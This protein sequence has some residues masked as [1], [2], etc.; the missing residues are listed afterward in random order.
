MVVVI[1]GLLIS[2]AFLAYSY[3]WIDEAVVL[4]LG[5][6]RG[7][8]TNLHFLN[9]LSNQNRPVMA[10]IFLGL[11]ASLFCLQLLLMSKLGSRLNLKRML[12]L[13]GV[14]TFIFSLSY[15]FLSNDLFAYL[16]YARISIIY[17]VSPYLVSAKEF[18]NVDLWVSLLHNVDSKAVYGPGHLIYS[19]ILMILAS[20]NKLLLNFLVM[21][22]MNGVLFYLAGWS[23]FRLY[24]SKQVFGLWFFNPLLIIELLINSH[25]DLL[26]V[27]LTVLAIYFWKKRDDVKAWVL[28]WLSVMMKYFS[29]LALP[30]F[31]LDEKGRSRYFKL[32]CIMI[33][34]F[35]LYKNGQVWY[36]SWVYM[37][38]PFI[39]LKKMS[40]LIIYLA[41]FLMLTNY[42]SFIK[43]ND[44]GSN[45]LF[46][47]SKLMLTGLI[48][49]VIVIELELLKIRKPKSLGPDNDF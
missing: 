43:T 26:M 35:L 28:F 21:K 13:S 40:W 7:F 30:A 5:S 2:L 25:N 48:L 23:I 37:F 29:L 10:T 3:I 19:I 6:T 44:W 36:F 38:L 1:T 42:F 41:G 32:L 34:L 12:V 31:Y 45:L 22:L 27:S 17:H 33:P 24:Q 20:P 46:P 39:N 4:L 8:F 11:L 47:Y 15:P 49:L 18:W 9:E 14:T 16:F